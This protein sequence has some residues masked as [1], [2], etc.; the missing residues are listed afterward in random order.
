VFG[1][2]HRQRFLE[3]QLSKEGVHLNA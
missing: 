3:C 2:S 1:A